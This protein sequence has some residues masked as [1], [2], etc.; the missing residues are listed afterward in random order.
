MSPQV[1]PD[2][3][4]GPRLGLGA[5]MAFRR[6]AEIHFVYFWSPKTASNRAQNTATHLG[7]FLVCLGF[8]MYFGGF[9]GFNY[10]GYNLTAQLLT[11]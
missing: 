10:S 6:S 7:D 11:I 5:Q 8:S 3:P 1:A 9:G 4:D 2:G